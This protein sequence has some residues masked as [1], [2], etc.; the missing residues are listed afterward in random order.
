MTTGTESTIASRWTRVD[1]VFVLIFVL[2]IALRVYLAFTL[3]YIHDEENNA[4]P[5]ARLISFTPGQLNLPLR[6]ENHPALPAYVAKA[7][8]ALFGTTPQGYRA[9]HVAL[10][11]GGLLMLYR[12][13]RQWYGPLAACWAAAFFAFNQ[14]FATVSSRVTAHAP[15]FFLV[16]AAIFAFSSFL[17]WQKPA[18]LY[19]S[20]LAVGL[21]FYCKE[22]SAL[23][24]P[25]F[26]LT[27]L[28]PGYRR[29][30]RTPFP[31]LAAAVFVAVIGADLYWNLT[32]DR[33][34]ARVSYG[35]QVAQ[36]ATY[37]S[38][39][40]RIGGLGVSPYPAM[41]YGREVVEAL[42]RRVTG[43]ALY[44]DT[45]EYPSLNPA[46]G[47]L[48]LGLVLFT[49]F[50]PPASD[51]ARGYLLMI[52]WGLFLFFTFIAKGDPPG[53]LA[54]VSWMWVDITLIP[55]VVL[56]GARLVDVKGWWRAAAWTGALAVLL[57][58]VWRTVA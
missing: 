9:L 30:L 19:V 39:L 53:R 34:T 31:Y 6:G 3:P 35:D 38:H 27:L 52:F 29:W 15:Y 49:S 40:E 13:A 28:L 20:G 10:G 32:T 50:R 44:D 8:G 21:A 25:L 16:I 24:L 56:S 58:D 4:I 22:H 45:V 55:A 11:L 47:A 43:N 1:L 54:P 57:F 26:F 17:R 7:S 37:A 12:L 51:G 2:A 14:Y 41:F 5:L 23:L 36:Q 18:Y 48:L 33:Q 46:L 42:Y